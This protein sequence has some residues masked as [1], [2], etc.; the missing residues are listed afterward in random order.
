MIA[1]QGLLG[2]GGGIGGNM[3]FLENMWADAR[4]QATT[5]LITWQQPPLNSAPTARRAYTP[6]KPWA[7]V[8]AAVGD[9]PVFGQLLGDPGSSK[10]FNAPAVSLRGR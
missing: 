3:F 1:F 5:W 8:S 10:P 9:L 7:P 2:L 4:C 6:R